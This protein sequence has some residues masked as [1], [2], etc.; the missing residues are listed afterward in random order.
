[1]KNG[2]DYPNLPPFVNGTLSLETWNEGRRNEIL[3]LFRNEVYGGI[4]DDPSLSVSHRVAD[5]SPGFMAGRAVRKIV[6]ITVRRKD[7]EFVF[8]FFLFIPNSTGKKPAPAIL[9][10][11]NRA[12]SDA[13]PSRQTLSPF[14][15][16]EMMI[17]RGY[18]AAVLV[19]HD[20]A[21]DYE[22]NFTTKFHRLFPEYVSRRPENAW[23]SITAW[24]W[25]MSRAIDYLVSDLQING[26]EIAV[27]GHSRGGKTSLWCGAQDARVSLVISSCS[28]CS[29]AAITRG[30]TGEHIKDIVQRFPFWFSRNYQKYADH[31]DTMPFDQHFLLALIAPRPLYLSDK[32][33]DNWCDPRSEFESL[34]Q[35][36]KIY[37]LYGKTDGLGETLPAPEQTVISGNLAYHIKSG[38]HNMDEYDWERYLNFCDRHFPPL[39]KF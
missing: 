19:T 1:M 39:G 25:A 16:A 27:A 9:T 20:I 37:K 7:R 30:K 31:E 2:N 35:A 22:E 32:T 17:A 28:G 21:P 8:L 29:G 4:P 14:W 12:L 36:G 3:E 34:N 13:D 6:E 26:N 23:G 10:I 11:C 18:A 38:S 5:S 33:F 15:P 24:A